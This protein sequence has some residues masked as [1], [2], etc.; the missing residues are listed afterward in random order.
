MSEGAAVP[1]H[2]D[3]SVTEL[4]TLWCSGDESA[5]EQLTPLVHA[6]LHRLARRQMRNERAG[7]TLQTTAV[8][9][10]AYLKLVD[11]TR[12][13]WQDRAHF[14]TM[15]ARLMRHILVDYARAHGTAKRGGGVVSVTLENVAIVGGEPNTDLVA[16]DDALRALALLDARKSQVVEMRFFAGLTVQETA[17]ALGVSP[18]TVMRDWQFAKKWLQRELSG[19]DR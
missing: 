8:V 2:R 12:V 9:N 10:E 18:E 1:Q 7:H 13:R 5:L 19:K 17:T 16:L 6:E 14:F 15:A 11:L 4:L 3:R